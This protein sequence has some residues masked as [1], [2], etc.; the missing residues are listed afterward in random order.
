MPADA[1]GDR[2][3]LSHVSHVSSRLTVGEGDAGPGA[4]PGAGRGDAAATEPCG[5][6]S[7]SSSAPTQRAPWP[8]AAWLA[9][10]VVWCVFGA[11]TAGPVHV[12]KNTYVTQ[13]YHKRA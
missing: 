13:T 1:G 8:C 9:V 12:H 6:A 2:A 5:G 4:G 7:V 11:S 3:S 10:P